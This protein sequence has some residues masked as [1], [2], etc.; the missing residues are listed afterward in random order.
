M[1][2]LF[3]CTRC[4]H[5]DITDLATSEALAVSKTA[6]PFICTQCLTGKWHDQFPYVRYEPTKDKVINPPIPKVTA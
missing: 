6:T 1:N 3:M 5:V 2:Q 4:A